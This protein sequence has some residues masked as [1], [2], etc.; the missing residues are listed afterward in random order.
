MAALERKKCMA[1]G[2]MCSSAATTCWNC[3]HPFS[4]VSQSAEGGVQKAVV[5]EEQVSTES[6]RAEMAFKKKLKAY[7]EKGEQLSESMEAALFAQCVELQ[8]LKAPASAIFPDLDEMVVNGRDGKYVVS[9]YVDAQN[10]N[11]AMLRENYTYSVEK[12]GDRWKCSDVFVDSS[13]VRW[14]EMNET[15]NQ[16][17]ANVTANSILWWI[18]GLIGTVITIFIIRAI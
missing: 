5:V 13:A 4:D 17:N 6:L 10:A 16:I 15:M 9:G 1:C 14:M 8:V 7:Q 3:G 18:L 11:G 2:S 12:I